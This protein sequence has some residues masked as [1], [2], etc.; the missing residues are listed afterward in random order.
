[1]TAPLMPG[2]TTRTPGL[3]EQ[4]FDAMPDVMFCVKD[5]QGRYLWVN[6]TQVRRCGFSSCAQLIGKTADQVMPVASGASAFAQ[7]AEIAR[8]LRPIKGLL[9]L[10]VLKSRRYWCLLSK[11]PLFDA[12]GHING[13]A[14]VARDLPRPNERH[15]SYWRLARF[16][17]YVDAHMAEEFQITQAARHASLSPDTLGRLVKEIFHVTPKQ[18]VMK[19]RIDRACQLLEETMLSITEVAL[20]CGYA[21]HSAF[22]RQ[23]KAA[24]HTTPSQYRACVKTQQ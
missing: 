5:A 24:T 15:R 3:F 9:R 18:W 6:D 17:D 4:I 23:F 7:D 14:S 22:T 12:D 19:K 13:F 21:D 16:I 8:T 1:M 20:A 2:W 11:F 10:Y